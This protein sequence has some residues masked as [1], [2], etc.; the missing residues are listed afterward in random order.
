MI[1]FYYSGYGSSPTFS[2][3]RE[4]NSRTSAKALYGMFVYLMVYNSI[5]NR[6]LQI[7]ISK[8]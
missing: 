5:S 2:M 1:V 3:N 4:H 6:F 8:S 7:T